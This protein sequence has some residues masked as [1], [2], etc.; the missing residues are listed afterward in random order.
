MTKG[1]RCLEEAI[2][3]AGADSCADCQLDLGGTWLF[4]V[5]VP[6][7]YEESNAHLTEIFHQANQALYNLVSAKPI[8]TDEVVKAIARNVKQ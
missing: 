6:D 3:C 7:G 5:R 1:R 8:D 2:D 4:H